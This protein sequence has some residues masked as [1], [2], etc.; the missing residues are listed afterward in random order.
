MRGPPGEG[1]V[2]RV[3]DSVH[4]RVAGVGGEADDRRGARVISNERGL[5]DPA[6]RPVKESVVDAGDAVKAYAGGVEGSAERVTATSVGASV[7]HVRDS[8]SVDAGG[9][10]RRSDRS[11]E[12]Y[13]GSGVA[14][15][16]PV[17]SRVAAGGARGERMTRRV[18]GGRGKEG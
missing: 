13:G 2:V 8:A 17:M 1:R 14:A 12:E 9:T 3:E 6:D 15:F 11:A 18:E 16:T 5:S 10:G 4:A 7:V